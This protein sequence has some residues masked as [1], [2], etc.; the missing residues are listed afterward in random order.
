MYHRNL[1]VFHQISDYSFYSLQ[2]L[3][4]RIWFW[5]RNTSV[6]KN[7]QNFSLIPTL[8]TFQMISNS[9]GFM[10]VVFIDSSWIHIANHHFSL[11]PMY[12]T[13]Q[14]QHLYLDVNQIR[15]FTGLKKIQIQHS[16]M[17]ANL[18]HASMTSEITQLKEIGE[19][20]TKNKNTSVILRF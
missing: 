2:H 13:F 15:S 18:L 9:V 5:F 1:L 19:K 12:I 3:S 7:F 11:L 17:T 10:L 8:T 6:F 14:I 4:A 20:K 16:H